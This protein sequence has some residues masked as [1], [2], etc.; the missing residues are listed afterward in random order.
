MSPFLGTVLVVLSAKTHLTMAEGN[1]HPTG[2]FLSELA[3]PA[4]Q[5]EAAGYKL[6]FATPGGVAPRMD[7]VS[8]DAKW[9]D[10]DVVQLEAARAFVGDRLKPGAVVHL[11]TLSERDLERFDGVM[12]PGGHAPME[13]LARDAGVA[14][15]L[16]HFHQHGKPTGLICHGPAALLATEAFLY[17]GY[18]MTAFSTAEERQE[19]D[20][21]HLDGHVP[22]YLD[23]ALAARGAIVEVGAPWVSQAVRDRELVTGRNPFSDQAFADLFL[24]ALAEQELANGRD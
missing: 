17:R 7:A 12:F 15:A 19:E 3:V 16:R 8:D 23:Q 2:Y 10:N 5:L 22:F 9:F 6:I 4:Q 18:R 21:G 1:L 24:E 11:E 20:A 13:D 14:L